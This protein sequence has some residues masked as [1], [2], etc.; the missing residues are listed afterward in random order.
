[1]NRLGS[2]R[3]LSPGR[4]GRF[5]RLQPQQVPRSQQATSHTG[6][7]GQFFKGVLPESSSQPP[8]PKGARKA[9]R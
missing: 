6:L 7:E 2:K 3:G 5:G 9:I 8:T 4:D 1:M